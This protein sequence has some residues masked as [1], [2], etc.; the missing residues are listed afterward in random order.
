MEKSSSPDR[1]IRPLPFVNRCED[2]TH[3]GSTKCTMVAR[4]GARLVHKGCPRE[5]Q[6]FP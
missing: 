6:I 2:E 4:V 3:E 5:Y 1:G